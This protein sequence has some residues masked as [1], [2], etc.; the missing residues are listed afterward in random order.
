MKIHNKLLC[1]VV[2]GA[3]I[4]GVFATGVQKGLEIAKED[5]VGIFAEA[6]LKL[7]DGSNVSEIYE[8]MRWSSCPVKIKWGEEEEEMSIFKHTDNNIVTRKIFSVNPAETALEVPEIIVS[9][10]F[11]DVIQT[12]KIEIS[13]NETTDAPNSFLEYTNFYVRPKSD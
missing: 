3:V 11:I 5:T 7:I 1:V 2:L 10:E 12:I 4:R 13:T 8:Q 6:E 9:S